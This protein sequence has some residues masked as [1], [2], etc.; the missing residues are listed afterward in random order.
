[1]ELVYTNMFKCVSSCTL[2]CETASKLLN[3]QEIE[4]WKQT[5][6]QFNWTGISVKENNDKLNEYE[7]YIRNKLIK[8]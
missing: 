4:E 7:P 2:L 3:N 8:L 1:M 5:F 6:I